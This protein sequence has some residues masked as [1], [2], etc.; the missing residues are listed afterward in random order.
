MFKITRARV[1]IAAA[2][3]ACLFAFG[4]W[5]LLHPASIWVQ[6]WRAQ[7][8]QMQGNVIFGPYPVEGDFPILR[9]RGVTTIVSLL[10]PDVPHEK[11]LLAEERERAARYGIKVLNYPMGSI[12]GQK[13]GRDY[14]KNSRAAAEAALAADGTAYIHCYLGLNRAKNVQRYLDTLSSSANYAGIG[15]TVEDTEAYNRA[16]VA[17]DNGRYAEALAEAGKARVSS[18][19]LLRVQA[20][21][22]FK[23]RDIPQARAHF[24]KLLVAQPQD[25]DATVGLGYCA[26]R[27]GDLPAA[28]AYFSSVINRTDRNI[29]ATEGLGYVRVRQGNRNDARR[30]FGQV[31]AANPSNTDARDAL[32]RLATADGQGTTGTTAGGTGGAD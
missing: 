16:Q 22:H 5:V 21:T 27:D 19:P 6:P 23:L 14:H 24:E 3:F 18:V 8:S 4:V 30:L 11:V 26:L 32:K 31:L 7:Q 1:A 10:N 28:D 9:E 29:A 15:R 20:W 13:F 2:L 17:Y 12:L 25:N